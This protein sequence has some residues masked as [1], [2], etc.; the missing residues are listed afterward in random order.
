MFCAP[1]GVTFS[2]R[3]PATNEAAS[4]PSS[5]LVRPPHMRHTQHIQKALA[6]MNWRLDH[7]VITGAG[8]GSLGERD[9][10]EP[11]RLRHRCAL[12]HGTDTA[13]GT[14]YKRRSARIGN[15]RAV[16]ATAPK[17]AALSHNALRHG[18]E[19]VD[20]N[21]SFYETRYRTRVVENP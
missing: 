3:M 6:E 9:Q 8:C 7:V 5:H 10:H 20:L 21:A 4:L 2:E 13:L 18:I 1:C 11:A 15:A 14:F 12:E 19:Y 16:T 17:I